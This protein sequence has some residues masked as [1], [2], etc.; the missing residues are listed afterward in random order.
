MHPNS[1][2]KML[3]LS[4]QWNGNKIKKPTEIKEAFTDTTL[5]QY[6]RVEKGR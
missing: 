4:R 6:V 3:I 5:D 1:N 2:S